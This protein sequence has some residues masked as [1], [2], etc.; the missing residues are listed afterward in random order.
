[1]KSLL[2]NVSVAPKF[3]KDLTVWV[4]IERGVKQGCPLSPLLFII[5]YDPLIFILDSLNIKCF[6]FADDIAIA[7]TTIEAIFPALVVIDNFSR[8]SGLGINKDKSFVITSIDPIRYPFI[9]DELA[10]SPWP[11]LQL[12][13]KGK[14][15]ALGCG[16]LLGTYSGRPHSVECLRW[17]LLSQ[18][19][20]SSS[21][22]SDC[23]F[24][25]ESTAEYCVVANH[26]NSLSKASSMMTKTL[27]EIQMPKPVY[28]QKPSDFTRFEETLKSVCEKFLSADWDWTF[29]VGGKV[30]RE[31]EKKDPTNAGL[32]MIRGYVV[33]KEENE[34]GLYFTPV[35]EM[36]REILTDKKTPQPPPPP[37]P[38]LHISRGVAEAMGKRGWEIEKLK[39]EEEDRFF[40]INKFEFEDRTLL[41]VRKDIWDWCVLCIQGEN[42]N[43]FCAHLLR[44]VDKW[45]IHQLL[46]DVREFLQ[47]ENYREYGTRLEK[48][49]TAKPNQ[50][51]DIFTYISRLDKYKEEIGHLEHL[52]KEAGE[53]LVLP[54]FCQVWKILSAVEKYP[55]YRIY[56]EKV[57]QMSPQDWIKLNPETIR[58]DLHKIHSNKVSLHIEDKKEENIVLQAKSHPPPPP[59]PPRSSLPRSRSPSPRSSF[60]PRE[61]EGRGMTQTYNTVR[62]DTPRRYS[63]TDQLKH[64]NCPEGV[65]LGHFRYGRCP[66]LQKGKPCNFLHTHTLMEGAENKEQTEHVGRSRSSSPIRPNHSPSRTDS[67]N[68]RTQTHSTDRVETGGVCDKCGHTHGGVC[69]WNKRCFICGGLHAAKICKKN[70]TTVTFGT[71]GKE[72]RRSV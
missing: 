72:R 53:T 4:D 10:R 33:K 30:H 61:K 19:K 52:A 42:R 22:H 66:R 56:T 68:S 37:P 29:R 38:P 21:I 55:D 18:L 15:S 36:K 5:C 43:L 14:A 70:H 64:F 41:R 39:E 32:Q 35:R 20:A 57:Q 47:T 54:K 8:L 48:F 6:A 44:E 40:K 59:P 1:M 25:L 23:G 65:C 50:G 17:K 27:K 45:D 9:R 60:V 62:A 24:R 58:T 26:K 3:G 63:M 67:H 51:E 7:T 16:G 31:I 12:R 28:L 11:D 34:K 49:F 71:Q 2:T 13:E 46:R 69:M